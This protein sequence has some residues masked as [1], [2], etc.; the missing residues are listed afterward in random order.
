MASYHGYRVLAS[1]FLMRFVGIGVY[2]SG[3]LFII[4]M[5]VTFNI[6]TGLA[7]FFVAS[8]STSAFLATFAAGCVQDQLSKRDY[9][10]RHVYAAGSI[11]L[12]MGTIGASY[13]QYFPLV[14]LCSIVMGAGVGLTAYSAQGVLVQWFEKRSCQA[15]MLALSGGGIGT[16][17]YSRVISEM[18]D[19]FHDGD[20]L[21]EMDAVQVSACEEW[22]PAM[23]Y[24]GVYSSVLILLASYFVRLPNPTEV[25]TYEKEVHVMTPKYTEDV[26]PR[27]SHVQDCDS[28][29]LG[30]PLEE[31]AE[32]NNSRPP[33]ITMAILEASK[34]SAVNSVGSGTTRE[35][36]PVPT[37][38]KLPAE[39]VGRPRG[40]L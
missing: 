5:M 1:T 17:V 33:E 13:S 21:C 12:A 30:L 25:D 32:G 37:A 20:E 26:N 8:S 19:A 22:R 34:L 14:I 28:N 2:Y 10:I 31:V 18:M 15:L 27:S 23:R 3:G 4:P 6:G 39:H 38:S 40:D 36:Q 35:V 29:F 16:L 7:A 11:F 9:S 24:M